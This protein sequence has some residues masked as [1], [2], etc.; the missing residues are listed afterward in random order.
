[1]N[2]GWKWMLGAIAIMALLA[3]CGAKEDA[4]DTGQ[5]G[6]QQAGQAGGQQGAGP[7]QGGGGPQMG[8]MADLMGKVKSIGGQTITLYKSN[9]TFG[10][11]G[12]RG[13][14][15]GDG[16]GQPPADGEMPQRPEGEDGGRMNMD[17][18]FSD[19]TVDVQ[20][21][22]ATKIVTVTFEN[23]EMKET[24][25]ALSD[26]K[27]DDIVSVMLKDD[28]QVAESITIR[29]GGFGFGGG[30]GGGRQ[31]NGQQQTETAQ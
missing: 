20:V 23:N 10:Q 28:T 30:G 22:D 1:M 2:K 21:T 9:M 29:T 14:G 24:E 13:P 3:G 5:Q 4:A 17:N 27:A 31:P 11:G 6:Q 15:G 12:G 18:M 8:M 7:G 25:I 19:E 16:E 26:L